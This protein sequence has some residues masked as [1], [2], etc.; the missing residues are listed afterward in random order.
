MQSK[1]QHPKNQ[2]GIYS[3]RRIAPLTSTSNTLNQLRIPVGTWPRYAAHPG[4]LCHV[5]APVLVRRVVS[6]KGLWDV[7]Q[8]Q[9]GPADPLALR[10]R[11]RHT[12][13]NTRPRHLELQ[14]RK[15][16]S[17]LQEGVGHGVYL[18]LCAVQLQARDIVLICLALTP[19]RVRPH[20]STGCRAAWKQQGDLQRLGDRQ[21]GAGSRQNRRSSRAFQMHAQRHSGLFGFRRGILHPHESRRR[22]S[23][24]AA[25]PSPEHQGGCARHHEDDRQGMALKIAHTL[26]VSTG[27]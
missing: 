22:V 21:G 16:A 23:A 18:A 24:S 7:C 1:V 4:K 26:I 12:R 17:H 13:A 10:P 15:H 20:S 14:L 2:Y 5:Q 9:L 19:F 3:S 6:E 8:R 25:A 11:V 27:F